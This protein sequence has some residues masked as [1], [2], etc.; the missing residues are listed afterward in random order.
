MV[1]CI[2]IKKNGSIQEKEGTIKTMNDVCKLSGFRSINN[3]NLQYKYEIDDKT[4]IYVY[5]KLKGSAGMENKYEMPPPIDNALFFG[6]ISL[7]GYDPKKRRFID[8]TQSEWKKLYEQL[9]GGFEDIIENDSDDESEECELENM[10]PSLLTKSG[11]LKDGFVVSD[12]SV[13]KKNKSS[14]TNVDSDEYS[15]SSSNSE[16]ESDE[17]IFSDELEEEEY[18]DES[19]SEN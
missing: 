8:F 10:D 5:G 18:S 2:L 13:S 16:C 4:D 6:T 11:Y 3:F 1:K 19:D 7:V 15:S 14:K 17:Y 12:E 9:Y